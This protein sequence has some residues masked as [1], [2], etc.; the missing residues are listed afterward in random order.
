MADN[1][2]L[3]AFLQQLLPHCYHVQVNNVDVIRFPDANASLY[4]KIKRWLAYKLL[5]WFA[6]R[7]LVYVNRNQIPT[8]TQNLTFVLSHADRLG[9]V[10]D[11]LQNRSSQELMVEL[12]LYRVLGCYRVRL[13]LSNATYWQKLKFI[14][15]TLRQRSQ[16]F[17]L[18][19]PLN[20]LNFYHLNAIGFALK[21]H[22]H[23][24][25]ILCTFV[26]QQYKYSRAGTV[27]EAEPGDIVID[28]GGCW[29]DTALYFANQVGEAGHVFCFEFLPENLNILGHNLE[30]NPLLK[31]RITTL[32]QAVWHRSGDC[33][34]YQSQGP[35]TRLSASVAASETSGSTVQTQAIDD[36]VHEHRLSQVNFIKLDIEGAELDALRGAEQTLKSCRPK[37]AISLYHREEDFYTIPEYLM[38]LEL[39]YRFY[40]DHFTIHQEETVLFACPP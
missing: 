24:L 11:A 3:T 10:F 1:L 33:M 37:L 13:P 21:L 36:F 12:L 17:S 9:A 35:G 2:F 40:L 15:K 5:G 8:S 7:N 38:S 4:L 22:A 31:A 26:L 39:G 34:T 19:P 28:A 25:N 29:G 6:N 30:L 23:E 14:Q 16:T 20:R 18:V 32:H 27:I